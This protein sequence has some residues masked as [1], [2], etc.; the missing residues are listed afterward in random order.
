MQ[1][2]SNKIK[3]LFKVYKKGVLIALATLFLSSSFF[4]LE[5][6][7]EINLLK[8]IKSE[9]INLENDSISNPKK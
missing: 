9:K 8:K 5:S 1:R 3:Y 6:S 4:V 2:L 7:K